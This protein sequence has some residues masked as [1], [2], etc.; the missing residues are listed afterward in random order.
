VFSS[1]SGA[2]GE[3]EAFSKIVLRLRFAQDGNRKPATEMFRGWPVLTKLTDVLAA[4]MQA[5][6]A[7][8]SVK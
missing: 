4:T 6:E 3:V 7:A 8:V 1:L 2:A 5:K